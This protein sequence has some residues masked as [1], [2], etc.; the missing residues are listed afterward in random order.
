MMAPEG[1]Y[2]VEFV[3]TGYQTFKKNFL[4][5][6]TQ[7]FEIK[8]TPDEQIKSIQQSVSKTLYLVLFLSFLLEADKSFLC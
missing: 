6:E 4:K 3:Y 7:L 8:L 1:T 2:D 5:V